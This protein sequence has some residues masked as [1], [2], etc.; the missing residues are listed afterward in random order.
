MRKLLILTALCSMML[1][2]PA[3]KQ[4][5][6]AALLCGFFRSMAAAA[7]SRERSICSSA[8]YT[9]YD[10]ADAITETNEAKARAAAVCA[11][12]L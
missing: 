4:K 2:T 6:E 7:E 1:A 9:A 12:G 5:A 11:V 8:N 10:C 3:P